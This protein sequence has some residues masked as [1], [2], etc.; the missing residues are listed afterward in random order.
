[1][2]KGMMISL[3]VPTFMTMAIPMKAGHL[4]FMARIQRNWELGIYC[5]PISGK[6]VA[7]IMI[8]RIGTG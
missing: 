1:M 5:M 4:S 2:V 7:T 6:M 3:S 8:T